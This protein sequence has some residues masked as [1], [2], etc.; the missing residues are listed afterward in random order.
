MADKL[1]KP[2]KI[3]QVP[4]VCPDQQQTFFSNDSIDNNGSVFF[5]IVDS[6]LAFAQ[7]NQFALFGKIQMKSCQ[8]NELCN[9]CFIEDM[10]PSVG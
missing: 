8:F 9:V 5:T 2:G 3:E 1:K 7:S 10:E 4:M 6:P